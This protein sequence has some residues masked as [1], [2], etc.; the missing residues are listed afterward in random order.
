MSYHLRSNSLVNPFQSTCKPGHSTETALLE[1][2]NDLLF[3]LDN[4]SI[5]I[6][7]VLDLSAAFD[8]SDHTILL[9]RLEHVCGIHGTAL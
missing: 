7:T 5:S 2:V 4:K 1:I 8:T 6:V 3:S 9:S